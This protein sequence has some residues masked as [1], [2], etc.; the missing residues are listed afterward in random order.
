MQSTNNL[1]MLLL[2]IKLYQKKKGEPHYQKQMLIEL[3]LTE[4]QL[5]N[6]NNLISVS[7]FKIISS[8]HY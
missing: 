7:N 1:C 3:L 4:R 5:K 6:I 8:T 2:I